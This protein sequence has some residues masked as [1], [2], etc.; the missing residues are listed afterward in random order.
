[1][2][3]SSKLSPG[4]GGARGVSSIS[5]GQ[6]GRLLCLQSEEVEERRGLGGG[7]VGYEGAFMG[8]GREEM[9]AVL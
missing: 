7:S 1:M 8:Q 6:S 9:G 3:L 2:S 4:D 5:G